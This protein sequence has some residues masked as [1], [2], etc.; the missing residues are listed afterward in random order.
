MASANGRTCPR[1]CSAAATAPRRHKS[2]SVRCRPPP[3]GTGLPRL[4]VEAP[5]PPCRNCRP[6]ISKLG[7]AALGRRQ[8]F[9]LVADHREDARLL[10]V[11]SDPV[12]LLRREILLGVNGLYRTD[13]NARA[14]IDAD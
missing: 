13:G 4:R 9:L 6:S 11:L 7:A 14:A 3:P 8:R 2:R 10:G 5:S 1:E 12:R